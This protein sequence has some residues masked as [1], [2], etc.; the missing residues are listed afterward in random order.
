MY[1]R[2]VREQLYQRL[3]AGVLCLQFRDLG[4]RGLW[5]C[6]GCRCHRQTRYFFIRRDRRGVDHVGA[7]IED[8]LPAAVGLKP[9]HGEVVADDPSRPRIR[10]GP[11]VKPKSPEREMP[12]YAGRQSS[13]VSPSPWTF[14]RLSCAL[15]DPD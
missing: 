14:A 7:R 5:R 12:A 8:P 9:P 2:V 11:V 6:R 4:D 15:T 3:R 13:V 1:A 10:N